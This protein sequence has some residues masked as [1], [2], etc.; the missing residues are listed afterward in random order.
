MFS[1]IERAKN[2]SLNPFMNQVYFYL[3]HTESGVVDTEE[4]VLIPL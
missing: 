2:I 4:R 3:R 1:T